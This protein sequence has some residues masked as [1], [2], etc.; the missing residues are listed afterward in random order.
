MR[1]R[2]LE[3]D[4]IALKEFIR[5]WVAFG[6]LLK[7]GGE[8]LAS[9]NAG[10]EQEFMESKSLLARKY[11]SIIGILESQYSPD[12]KISSILSQSVSL[13]NIAASDMQSRKLGN[14]WHVS[15][16]FLNKRLGGLEGKREE[17]TKISTLGTII[18]PKIRR[19]LIKLFI[20][21]ILIAILTAGAYVGYRVFFVK[22]VAE[23]EAKTNVPAQAVES[24]VEDKS[25]ITNIR[26][27]LDQI[28]SR[29]KK[30]EQSKIK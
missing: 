12:N 7:Q 18:M 13:S 8:N 10:K 22:T 11:E 24:V 26:N 15:Y 16:I 25:I 21:V 29:I 2:K 27:M 30:D 20:F 19:W 1:D 28:S 23:P 5:L 6:D 9:K 4:I 14:D 3:A 17:L